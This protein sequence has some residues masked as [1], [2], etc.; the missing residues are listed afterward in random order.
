MYINNINDTLIISGGETK[1]KRFIERI[2]SKFIDNNNPITVNNFNKFIDSYKGFNNKDITVLSWNILD[3][4]LGNIANRILTDR[5]LKFN[6][7]I[8]DWET[9]KS[10]IIKLLKHKPIDIICLQEVPI[11]Y[12]KQ[13]SLKIHGVDPNHVGEGTTSIDPD[14]YD[15]F[16]NKYEIFFYSPFKSGTLTPSEAPDHIPVDG[17]VVM[18][19][20][21]RFEIIR[22]HVHLLKNKKTCTILIVKDK[23]TNIIYNIMSVHLK[24]ISVGIK[25]HQK[26]NVAKIQ[27]LIDYCY[28]DD[29]LKV[30]PTIIAGDFNT[31][32]SQMKVGQAKLLCSKEM[33]YPTILNKM[34]GWISVADYI[35]LVNPPTTDNKN[36]KCKYTDKYKVSVVDKESLLPTL[37]WPSDHIPVIA[38]IGKT[39]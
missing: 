30:N 35:M 31:L 8:Y 17:N 26:K 39:K 18:I 1:K 37:T 12:T 23:N 27:E 32:P 6:S 2:D 7:K 21:N 14:F 3:R 20:L 9:R 24:V 38:T 25:N 33:E 11:N 15:T 4:K 22:K 16:K 10:M 34:D 13:N 36:I 29:I 5:K 28:N 19:A